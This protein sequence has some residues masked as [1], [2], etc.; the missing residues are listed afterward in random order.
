MD[1]SKVLWLVVAFALGLCLG[2]ILPLWAFFIGFA[3][4]FAG[5]YVS[6]VI[7]NVITPL[8]PKEEP[9]AEERHIGFQQNLMDVD[10]EE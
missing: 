10:E 7:A 6:A 1:L 5:F 2:G 9:E 8:Y 4:L 3:V